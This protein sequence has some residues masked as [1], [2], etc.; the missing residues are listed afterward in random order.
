[1]APTNVRFRGQSGHGLK[2]TWLKDGVRRLSPM[3]R[4]AMLIEGKSDELQR[5]ALFGVEG[6]AQ[7]VAQNIE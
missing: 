4:L 3:P 6:V 2:R 5:S 7:A 1:M